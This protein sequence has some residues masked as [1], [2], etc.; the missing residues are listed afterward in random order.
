[1]SRLR[2]IFVWLCC[3]SVILTGASSRGYVVCRTADGAANIEAVSADGRCTHLV[4]SG[5]ALTAIERPSTFLDNACRDQL[6]GQP[7]LVPATDRLTVPEARLIEPPTV[8]LLR[9]QFADLLRPLRR[10]SPPE[11]RAARFR[12]DASFVRATVVLIV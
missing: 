3:V 5:T 12:T 1:M 8:A 6:L 10:G 9:S 4:D 11:P 2:T 7:A